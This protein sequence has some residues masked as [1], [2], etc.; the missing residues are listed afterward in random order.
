MATTFHRRQQQQQHLQ[1]V[2]VGLKEYAKHLQ[3]Q[4]HHA[5]NPKYH[6]WES[7]LPKPCAWPL[8]DCPDHIKRCPACHQ[9]VKYKKK[10]DADKYFLIPEPECTRKDDIRICEKHEAC[11]ER[12][13]RRYYQLRLVNGHDSDL[14]ELQLFRRYFDYVEKFAKTYW[15]GSIDENNTGNPD[16]PFGVSAETAKEYST[17]KEV[18]FKFAP[19][20][21]KTK[22]E[23]AFGKGEWEDLEPEERKMFVDLLIQNKEVGEMSPE[24]REFLYRRFPFTLTKWE[25]I[26]S[27]LEKKISRL[28]LQSLYRP[29]QKNR[30]DIDTAKKVNKWARS[31]ASNVFARSLGEEEWTKMKFRIGNSPWPS[32][33][34]CNSGNFCYKQKMAW[35]RAR[36]EVR[37][38]HDLEQS[39]VK[40]PAE[41]AVAV[42]AAGPG[43]ME[44][45]VHK[46]ERFV[47]TN[48]MV[49][50]S[51]VDLKSTRA[52][53]KKR[54][55]VVVDPMMPPSPYDHLVPVGHMFSDFVW[56]KNNNYQLAEAAKA[57]EKL[58]RKYLEMDTNSKTYLSH[59][60]KNRPDNYLKLLDKEKDENDKIWPQFEGYETDFHIG[61]R[62][63]IQRRIRQ[64]IELEERRRKQER[65]DHILGK[66]KNLT[67]EKYFVY[68]KTILYDAD[69]IWARR[70]YL[71]GIDAKWRKQK[72]TLE[73]YFAVLIKLEKTK[74]RNWKDTSEKDFILRVHHRINDGPP[75]LWA[76]V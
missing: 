33:Y 27:W 57:E 19:Q 69:I 10:E 31:Q 36:E 60:K 45:L 38:L 56:R 73:E 66:K 20:Q 62:E 58:N 7:Y 32:A 40:Q 22:L 29:D 21:A 46:L 65:H 14:Y 74:G 48:P 23:K 47:S 67:L 24:E 16:A 15:N 52:R 9:Y 2:G 41:A 30:G 54:V 17:P 11:K 51:L 3:G 71:L 26:S 49:A 6:A 76:K 18:M 43:L 34:N 70:E 8:R 12:R 63:R 75:D 72:I 61:I 64:H 50:Q 68:L 37:A 53:A 5:W 39:H 44:R 59:L 4:I 35:K 55:K 42:A 13:H 25:E 28:L 1:L